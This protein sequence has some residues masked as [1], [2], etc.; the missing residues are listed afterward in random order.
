MADLIVKA[1]H[2]DPIYV[3]SILY[4]VPITNWVY[5]GKMDAHECMKR[6]SMILWSTYS[7]W[8]DHSTCK[9][10]AVEKNHDSEKLKL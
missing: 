2:L 6:S 9:K 3:I 7:N 1:A 10:A 5:H 8:I 4:L